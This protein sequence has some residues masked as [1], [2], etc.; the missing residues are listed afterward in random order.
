MSVSSPN[1]AASSFQ[2]SWSDSLEST[3]DAHLY[4]GQP[5][6]ASLP[7]TRAP[8]EPLRVVLDLE[9]MSRWPCG[10]LNEEGPEEEGAGF[11]S[12]EARGERLAGVDEEVEQ[13]DV[14]GTAHELPSAGADHQTQPAEERG[15]PA[16][17]IRGLG[18]TGEVA[19]FEAILS[20]AASGGTALSSQA[21][22]KTEQSPDL[23]T[24]HVLGIV[25]QKRQSR[26]S[27]KTARR[28]LLRSHDTG[29]E[30]KVQQSERPSGSSP[31]SSSQH[32]TLG[33]SSR[34]KPWWCSNADIFVGYTEDSD[35]QLT[36]ADVRH[37]FL[38]GQHLSAS[39]R[40][41]RQVHPCPSLLH[42]A[43]CCI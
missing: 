31:S 37:A 28:L 6:S 12:A 43:V 1:S 32:S 33:A 34:A 36:Y 5:A 10:T 14:T 18:T 9:A 40:F 42:Q 25:N 16:S 19:D 38:A 24:A 11:V 20:E 21:S 3:A 26:G 8:G 23:A 17:R 27:A 29:E 22:L 4:V 7:R 15:G 35:V 13:G 2:I 41:K 30:E 39:T